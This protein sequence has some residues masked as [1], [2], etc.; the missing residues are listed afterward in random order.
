MPVALE[1][2]CWTLPPARRGWLL[3]LAKH[4]SSRI[5][6][7]LCWGCAH[8]HWCPGTVGL[9]VGSV[10]GGSEGVVQPLPCQ[11]PVSHRATRASTPHLF[12][13][14]IFRNCWSFVLQQVP[15]NPQA[16][17]ANSEEEKKPCQCRAALPL[18]AKSLYFIYLK[19]QTGTRCPGRLFQGDTACTEGTGTSPIAFIHATVSP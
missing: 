6:G 9:G 10:G 8:P 18:H 11:P 17:C 19:Q 15:S 14:R 2:R 5:L 3:T 16:N 1:P 12:L 7:K 4:R 13:P